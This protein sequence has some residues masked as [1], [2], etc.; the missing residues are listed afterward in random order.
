MTRGLYLIDPDTLD[1]IDSYALPRPQQGAEVPENPFKN[2]SGGAY[3]YV[4]NRDRAVI[5]TADGHFLVIK[6][7]GNTLRLVKDHD[8]SSKLRPGEVLNSGLPG[9]DGLL[10]FVTKKNGGVGTLN[11]RTGR[12][13]MVRLGDGAEGQIE[14]SIAVG[15]RDEAYVATNRKALPLLPQPQ[16]QA[17]RRLGGDLRQLRAGQAGTGRRRHRDHADGPAERLRRHNRQRRPNA[18]RRLPHRQAPAT[19]AA[20]LRGTG[21][22]QGRRQH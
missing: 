4:D 14:N 2:F 16:G 15:S 20:G 8:L 1:V 13:R 11:L 3:F 22:R 12:V 6:A 19:Q 10:W 21:L 7:D 17:G 18:G 5:G 9:T